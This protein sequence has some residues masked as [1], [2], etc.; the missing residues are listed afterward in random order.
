V[1]A[2]L[3]P[4]GSARCTTPNAWMSRPG[5]AGSPATRP[6]GA[7]PIRVKP[8]RARPSTRPRGP[9]RQVGGTVHTTNPDTVPHGG[10]AQ[11]RQLLAVLARNAGRLHRPHRDMEPE[12]NS[13]PDGRGGPAL[14]GAGEPHH[15]REC[16]RGCDTNIEDEPTAGAGQ[17]PLLTAGELDAQF[18]RPWSTAITSPPAGQRPGDRDVPSREQGI[19]YPLPQTQPE[20]LRGTQPTPHGQRT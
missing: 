12:M 8:V 9:D 4:A 17:A 6:R 20:R 19:L 5:L 3:G 7:T 10:D 11:R 1:Q 14:S 15:G 16:A 2:Y 13:P 18:P